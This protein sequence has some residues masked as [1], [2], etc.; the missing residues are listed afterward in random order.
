MY[1]AYCTQKQYHFS[2]TYT[3][4]CCT[5]LLNAIAVSPQIT[6]FD[7]GVEPANTG[8]MAGVQCM[9]IKGD[10]PLDIFWSLNAIPIVTGQHS[11]TISRMN[12]RTSA[13]NIESLDSKHR[14]VY[15]CIARN[16]AGFSEHQSE[17]QVNG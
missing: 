9:V 7:F 17:L 3:D 14:G 10:L 15:Q 13:L 5:S 2:H 8:E 12:S 1:Y 6:P 4:L 16:K 11:F